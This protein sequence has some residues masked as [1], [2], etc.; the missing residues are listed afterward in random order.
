M[1]IIINVI[2]LLPLEKKRENILSRL[3]RE[4]EEKEEGTRAG[5]GSR[6]E[7]IKIINYKI[8]ARNVVLA[9]RPGTATVEAA[10]M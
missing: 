4:T 3:A 10:V 1:K 6:I 9:H 7:C 8:R 2:L 5:Y